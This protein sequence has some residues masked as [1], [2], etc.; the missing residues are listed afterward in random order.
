M[1]GRSAL[2]LGLVGLQQLQDE[3]AGAPERREER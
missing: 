3:L 1:K 2:E